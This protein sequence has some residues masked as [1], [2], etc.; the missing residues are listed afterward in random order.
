MNDEVSLKDYV[1]VI[2][3]HKTLIALV[4]LVSLVTAF[5]YTKTTEPVYVGKAK[6]LVRSAGVSSGASQLAGLA[7]MA[8]INL[9]MPSS[10]LSDLSEIIK[11]DTVMKM[12]SAEVDGKYVPFMPTLEA[13]SNRI[14]DLKTK[15]NGSYLEL[16]LEH[17]GKELSAIVCNLYLKALSDYWNKLNYSAAKNKREYIEEQLPKVSAELTKIENKVKDVTYL[18]STVGSIGQPSFS[19]VDVDR[20]KR[21]LEI[22]STTYVMLRKE[23]ESTKLEEAKTISPFSDIE[24]AEVP[25]APERPRL[26]VNA[27]VGLVVGLMLGIFLAFS[28]DYFW[29]NVKKGR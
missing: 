18:S 22:L 26:K 21:E 17:S 15:I 23:L 12:V 19:S 16:R 4:V 3:R 6:I 11:A 9:N 13:R 1:E 24:Y 5:I 28:A 10:D 20:L 29:S 27:A 7:A 2:L 25:K 8:G 14:G